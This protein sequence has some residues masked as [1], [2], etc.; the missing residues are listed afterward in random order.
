[1]EAILVVDGLVRRFGRLVAIGD[2]GFALE[3]GRITSLIGPNGAG[4]STLFNLITGG[5]RPDSG[6][7]TFAGRRI[8]GLKPHRIAELGIAR[9]SQIA[10]PFRGLSVAD[11]VRVG[12]LYGR[13]GPRDVE[14][15]IRQALQLTGLAS[16]AHRL[17]H[18]LTIGQLR[19]MELA[20][21]I[22]A[23]PA[24]LLADEP[25]AGLNPAEGEAVL[26][27]LR[28]LVGSGLTV[29]LVEHD[30]AAVMKVSDRILVLDAGRL[31]ADGTPAEIVRDPKVIEAYLGT[32]ATA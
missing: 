8:D 14:A 29:L 15:T 18:E 31:I 21:A 28:S 23:R 24:L 22:A 5:V 13:S 3:R 9:S 7:V 2:V 27:T 25:L 19:L 11:N 17:A 26:E 4:K 6:R 1:M 16:L 20:R 12:A 10:R 32:E 30:V